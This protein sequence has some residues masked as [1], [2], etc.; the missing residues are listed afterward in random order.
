MDVYV[1]ITA[2]FASGQDFEV[3]T[4]HSNTH[5]VIIT[6]YPIDLFGIN[7]LPW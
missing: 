7:L 2:G 4:D 6:T 3:V 5:P 1:I